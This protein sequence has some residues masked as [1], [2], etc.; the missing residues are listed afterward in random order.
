MKRAKLKVL[1]L[2]LII[3]FYG[4]GVFAATL[5]MKVVAVNPSKDKS[6]TT[7][8]KQ[9]FP[10]EVTVKDVK[11]SGG[12][13]IDYDHEQGLYY[14][15]KADVELAPGETKVYELV[16]ND[17]WM[18]AEEKIQEVRTRTASVAARFEQTV[19]ANQADAIAKSIYTR[20]DEILRTQNDQNVTRKQHIADYR[21]NKAMLDAI[22]KDIERLEELLVQIGGPPVPEALEKSEINLKHPTTK[23]TWIIIFV[24]LVFIAILGGSFYFI[25]M[26]QAKITENI[27]S[28]EKGHSYAD[29]KK[30]DSGGEEPQS[31]E[32]N[33]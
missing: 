5:K 17:V 24:I 30:K 11:D 14:A 26:G 27:F 15:F 12:L 22:L 18:I 2:S 8:I 28:K 23:T 7:M 4:T 33:T 29:F 13:E 19:Y 3:A 9:H 25:W 6:R 1:L 31:P 32:E 10:K 21:D 16:V 20:L